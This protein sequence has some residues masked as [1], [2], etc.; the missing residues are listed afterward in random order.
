MLNIESF[1]PELAGCDVLFPPAA[2]FREYYQLG[3]PWQILEDINVKSTIR[4]LRKAE[5]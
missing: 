3:N 2:Y 1:A 5:K 4:L